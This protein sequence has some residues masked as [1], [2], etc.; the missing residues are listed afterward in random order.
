MN[1]ARV[2]PCLLFAALLSCF[3]LFTDAESMDVVHVSARVTTP[4]INGCD[5]AVQTARQIFKS[6]ESGSDVVFKVEVIPFDMRPAK[7][8]GDDGILVMSVTGNWDRKGGLSASG[9]LRGIAKSVM[10]AC[11]TNNGLEIE[12]DS[13]SDVPSVLE[14]LNDNRPV[15]IGYTDKALRIYY[16]DGTYELPKPLE[17]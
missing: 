6:V 9:Y 4:Y 8:S 3:P 16:N 7:L 14:R 17:Q 12:F 2:K 10:T 13:L 5:D 1:S 15:R 11:M